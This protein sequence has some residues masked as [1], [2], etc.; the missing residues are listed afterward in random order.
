MNT[1]IL[2]IFSLKFNVFEIQVR[3]DKMLSNMSFI[4]LSIVI[5]LTILELI[6]TQLVSIWFVV[7]GIIA[8]IVSLFI[9]SIFI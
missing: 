7:A 6:T 8:F 3:G 5:V 1:T 4:W 9:D 2:W